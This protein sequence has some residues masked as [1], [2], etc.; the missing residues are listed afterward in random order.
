MEKL[1]HTRQRGYVLVSMLAMVAV[2]GGL[3]ASMYSDVSGQE[4]MSSSLRMKKRVLSAADSAVQSVWNLN[5]LLGGVGTDYTQIRRINKDS[6]YDTTQQNLDVEAVVCFGGNSGAGFGGSSMDAD[7]SAEASGIGFFMF[8]AYGDA[9]NTVSGTFSRV[10][11][12]GYM[13]GPGFDMP[14]VTPCP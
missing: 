14:A 11:M 8:T 1:K 6:D 10:A 9:S 13:Q 7:E 12:G 2:M 3:A 4:K 5:E